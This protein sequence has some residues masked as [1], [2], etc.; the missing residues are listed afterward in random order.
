MSAIC[1]NIIYHTYL[2]DNREKTIGGVQTYIS[3][4]SNVFEKAGLN[5]RVI[6]F[7]KKDFVYAITDKVSVYGF[8]IKDK[9]VRRRYQ[10]LY[11]KCIETTGDWQQAITI[12][13]TDIMIP[14]KVKKQAICIQ[15]G[16]SWDIPRT[17]KR[18]RLLQIFLRMINTQRIIDRLSRV[19]EVV[20]VD[21]NFQN[22][23]RTQI[24]KIENSISV[25][26]NYT[27]IFSEVSKSSKCI[28][29]I[30]A[31]RFFEYRGTRIFVRAVERL[32]SERNDVFVTIAGDGPDKKWM[33][34]QLDHF[35]N[36]KFVTYESQESYIIHSDQHI[37]VVPTI[38]SEG[39]SLS[40]LE[41]MSSQCAVI[42]SDVG[43]MTNIVL[44]GYNGIIVGAGN[45][46]QLYDA[47]LRLV[48][49][50]VLRNKLAKN[51]RETVVD[52]FSYEKWQSQWI[53][54]INK[55]D[56]AGY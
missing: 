30:F 17:Q 15:H 49:D 26:P 19:D 8:N 23:Y 51:A 43:G 4:L 21:Y 3:D 27:K 40:L 28:N 14:K 6:Q 50:P 48:N 39:T 38:G 20:C 34:Q 2:N 33:Q 32:L 13:A 56:N 25:I 18:C 5:V 42:C 53:E 45:V 22:W 46:Q 16:I 54:V 41:A 12:F 55:L 44:D 35:E 11:N 29:L 52:A 37:A 10:K 1:I 9:N 31:R 7:S 36:V 47:M 24:D